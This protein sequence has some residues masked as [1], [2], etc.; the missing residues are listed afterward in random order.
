MQL[1]IS[2][3]AGS[4]SE[5]GG[6]TQA[7]RGRTED[8]LQPSW[9]DL[10]IT[11]VMIPKWITNHYRH[12]HVPVHAGW[13]YMMSGGTTTTLRIHVSPERSV[14]CCRSLVH[15]TVSVSAVALASRESN[16]AQNKFRKCWCKLV[17]S[18]RIVCSNEDNN[19]IQLYL[20]IQLVV[21]MLVTD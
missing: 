12:V 9:C 10:L 2:R 8:G 7:V 6:R 14:T 5:H 20:I 19:A 16:C 13:S 4:I 18:P 15:A 3:K 11:S 1:A 21:M 17:V